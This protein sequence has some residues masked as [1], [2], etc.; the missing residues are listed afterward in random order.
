[1]QKTTAILV[2]MA[3]VLLIA[4]QISASAATVSDVSANGTAA[5]SSVT[6][7]LSPKQQVGKKIFFDKN[8]SEPAGQSCS[9]CHDPYYGFSDPD[10]ILPV[11]EGVISGRVGARNAPT[12]AYQSTAPTFQKT[13]PPAPGVLPYFGGQFWDGRAK[14]LVEQAKAPFLNPLEMNNPSKYMVVRDVSKSSYAL[15]FKQVYGQY[16]FSNVDNAYDCIADAIAAYEKSYELNK[17]NSKFDLYLA[18]KA[19]LTAKELQGFQLFNDFDFQTGTPGRANC[20][21]CHSLFPDPGGTAPPFTDRRYFNVGTPRNL[22]NPF[23]YLP[24]SMN[25]DGRDFIDYGLAGF[26]S[27]P[28]VKP[29]PDPAI[30]GVVKVPTLRNI[31]RTAPYMH[32]GAFQTLETVVHFYNKRDVP[33]VGFG[34]PEVAD[35]VVGGI[36]GDQGLT[37]EEEDCIV[38][39]LKTLTDDYSSYQ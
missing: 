22:N 24:L 23:L 13:P 25:P 2:L 35:N 29:Y 14:N 4:P 38:A 12:A 20:S 16:V 27:N 31:A 32:N 7:S 1:M 6:G 17:F 8:L 9:S 33:G 18:G 34:P 15:L 21:I 30:L 36:I 19:Q 10:K 5:I 26:G 28:V 11:S 37:A 3:I 39:F